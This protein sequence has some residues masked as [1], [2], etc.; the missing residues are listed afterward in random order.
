MGKVLEF[1]TSQEMKDKLLQQE[2][3]EVLMIIGEIDP[4]EASIRLSQ[5]RG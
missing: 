4:V 3:R 5:M 1:P 2:I